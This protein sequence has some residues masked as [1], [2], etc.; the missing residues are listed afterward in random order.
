MLSI[1]VDTNVIVSAFM[2]PNGN[3]AQIARMIRA[4]DERIRL[5]CNAEILAEYTEVLKRKHFRFDEKEVDDFLNKVNKYSLFHEP[6][7][8]TFPMIDEKDRCFYDIAVH[9]GARLITGNMK[10]YPVES[11]VI[12]P[13]E[14]LAKI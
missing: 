11:F 14:F 7:K 12:S 2:S 13:T 3:P 9:F 6:P 1:V 10:H 8:S 4:N 5:C